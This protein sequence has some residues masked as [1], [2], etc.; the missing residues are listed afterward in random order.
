M[1]ALTL[2]PLVLSLDRAYA[3]LGFLVLMVAARCGRRARP[4]GARRWAWRAAARPSSAP[5]SAS[6]HQR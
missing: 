3:A 2:G 1:G 5:G 6:S 4:V